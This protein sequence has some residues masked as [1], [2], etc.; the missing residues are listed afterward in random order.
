MG[1]VV[2]ACVVQ[3]HSPRKCT[4]WN[5]VDSRAWRGPLTTRHVYIVTAPSVVRVYVTWL[6]YCTVPYLCH[7]PL[8]GK[9]SDAM[10]ESNYPCSA[11]LDMVHAIHFVHFSSVKVTT[12]VCE[13]NSSTKTKTKTI[14]YISHLQSRCEARQ[15]R[16]QCSLILLAATLICLRFV[17]SYTHEVFISRL[18][19][20]WLIARVRQSLR[21]YDNVWKIIFAQRNNKNNVDGY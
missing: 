2:L 16:S 10:R 9:I 14:L 6:L 17:A 11:A 12:G 15:S 7:P 21:R 13:S 19:I 3:L 18:L 4:C 20:V 8:T 1:H 5:S